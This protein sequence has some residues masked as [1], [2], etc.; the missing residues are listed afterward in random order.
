MT[1]TD[2][3][4]GKKLGDYTIE[5]TVGYGGM[6]RVYKGFD[7][8]LERYAAVKI[9]DA[10]LIASDSEQEYR[11][12]FTREARAIA[13]LNHP[14]IVGVYQ[15]GQ[16]ENIYYM[17]MAFLQGDDL[18]AI[19]KQHIKAGTMMPHAQAVRIIRDIALALDY[20]HKENVIHRD[21]KPSNIMVLKGDG[22]AVLT[23]FGLALSVP[24]GTMGN[25]FGS[26]HYVAPEQAVSSAR[27]VPQSDLY[28]LGIVLY[29]MLTGRVPF[30]DQSAMSVALKHLSEPPPPPR[31]INARIP[32]H[33]EDVLMKVLRK[34]PEMRYQTGYQ[35]V[36]ALEQAFAISDDEET[37]ELEDSK[38]SRPKPIIHSPAV[39]KPKDD[40]LSSKDTKSGLQ[41]VDD[42][43]EKTITEP[44]RPA[45]MPVRVSQA[46]PPTESTPMAKS[47]RRGSPV[48]IIAAVVLLLV[49]VGGGLVALLS[50]RA[51]DSAFPITQTS[52]SIYAT[53]EAVIRAGNDTQTA[54]AVAAIP[55]DAVTASPTDNLPQ[56]V[57]QTAA[58]ILA[59]N[60]VMSAT[61]FGTQTAVAEALS[62]TAAPLPTDTLPPTDTLE[63]IAED[64]QIEL[65]YDGRTL[66]LRNRSTVNTNITDLNFT[67]VDAA[68]GTYDFAA[69]EWG[70][71]AALTSLRSG[72]CFQVWTNAFTRLAEPEECN[73]RQ[74]FANRSAPS[75]FWLSDEPDAVF[76]VSRDDEL[77]AEC[78]AAPTALDAEDDGSA[79]LRCLVDIRRVR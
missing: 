55:T 22:R 38:S 50:G 49:I 43:L 73:F 57:T 30:D 54:A 60:D 68:G 42:K 35:F 59:T 78:P 8:K 72:D 15:F 18:R 7:P 71:N 48:V 37:H 67:R 25:T 74:G 75:W 69:T 29:E 21:V 58:A 63:P 16:E 26:V 39:E 51:S 24:E 1:Q 44:V 23:D 40:S 12:R 17:A 14:N 66:I 79:W 28:S 45:P 13:R 3:L 76:K 64:A 70:N 61:L 41:P 2:P 6:A 4:I 53:N 62:A 46:M 56:A 9:I 10:H 77:L 52:G 19:L 32:H 34:E 27:A 36:Q 5:S 33:V 31:D 65:L 20:A 11:E 47:E